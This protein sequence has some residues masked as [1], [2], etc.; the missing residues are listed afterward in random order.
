MTA[1]KRIFIAHSMGML[2]K[3]RQ[4]AVEA[5]REHCD[6]Y[7][8]GLDT[9]QV[10]TNEREILE[11]NLNAIK[12]CTEMWV[13]WDLSSLGTIFDMGCAYALGKPIHI[14]DTKKHHWVK[15]ILK[16]VGSRIL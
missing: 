9:E 2:E 14:V 16:N 6:V 4:L 10:H 3:A 7:V 15:F 1:G 13:I 8:P 5:R 11:R 12:D